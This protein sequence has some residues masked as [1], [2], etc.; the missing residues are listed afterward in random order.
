MTTVL[1]LNIL[2]AQIKIFDKNITFQGVMVGNYFSE[3]TWY[4]IYFNGG[5]NVW[6]FI[7][8][9]SLMYLPGNLQ[10]MINKTDHVFLIQWSLVRLPLNDNLVF[11]SYA[12]SENKLSH[13][14]WIKLIKHTTFDWRKACCSTT[15]LA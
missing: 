12:R 9:I 10:A 3:E 13:R 11:S 1:P 5:N 4:F 15:K 8:K 2:Q 14:I 6:R 7:Y